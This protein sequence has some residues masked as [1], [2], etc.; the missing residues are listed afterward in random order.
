MTRTGTAGGTYSATP[1][2][3]SIDAATGDVNTGT[4]TPGTYTVRYNI[5]PSGGCSPFS[6][7]TTIS[8]TRLQVATFSYTGTP[9]CQTA[10]NPLP[11][12]SGGGVAGTF[13]ASPAGLVFVS[14]STGQVNLSSSTP[15]TYT[16]TNTIAASG[17]CPQVVATSQITI[18]LQVAASIAYPAPAAF[19]A[20]AGIIAVTLTGTPGGTYSALPAGLLIDPST[21][22]VNTG[23]STPGT[24]TVTY[25]LLPSGG[26]ISSK[27]TA[28]ITVNALPL[29]ITGPDRSICS[30]ASTQLGTTSIS[31]HTYSWTSNPAGIYINTWQIQPFHPT[32][33]YNLYSDRNNYR[34]RM[35]KD[36]QCN[37]HCKPDHCGN[38]HSPF[39][40]QYVQADN[41]YSLSSN[42]AGTTYTW[43]PILLSGTST[44]DSVPA[45]DLLY[46]RQSLTHQG[47]LQLFNIQLLQMQTAVQIP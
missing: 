33:K 24:Y 2:G 47:V 7:S 31:G 5:A 46:L 26:C 40:R 42:I 16:V 28:P 10:A 29:A 45:Q 27:R 11:T 37:N 8:I 12:F 41:K 44:S 1:A 25:T 18:S 3:L 13:S 36:K 35:H 21:G 22:A 34:N 17:P 30:G 14:T 43:S 15:G 9:Y 20:D 6:T 23:T 39:V 38:D 4:S 32:C 19:C